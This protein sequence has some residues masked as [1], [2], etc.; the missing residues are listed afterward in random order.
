MKDEYV[1]R[2]IMVS[3]KQERTGR[4]AVRCW[5]VEKVTARRKR[6]NKTIVVET[7]NGSDRERRFTRCFGI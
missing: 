5:R 1:K 6:F 7:I 3:D 4:S 2:R